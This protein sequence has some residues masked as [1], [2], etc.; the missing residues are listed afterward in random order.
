MNTIMKRAG[1]ALGL[2][3]GVAF[4]AYA[5]TNANTNA[6]TNTPG[7]QPTPSVTPAKS[8]SKLDSADRDF[9]ENAAQSGHMEIAGSK[10]ALEKARNQEVKSY[11]QMMIDDHT[12]VGEQLNTL[13]KSKGYEPPTEPSMMMQAKLKTLGMRD[14]GFDKAY[15]E[16]VGIDAHEDAI[17]LFEKASQ[18]AKDADV[19]KFAADTLPALKQHRDKAK[20]LHQAVAG[21]KK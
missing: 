3:L 18:E 4:G 16:S 15:L 12:K 1:L 14:E 9:L 5:Q 2:S 20:A 19:K 21:E 7:P 11:A 6:N 13:A 17:K 8:D 10:M